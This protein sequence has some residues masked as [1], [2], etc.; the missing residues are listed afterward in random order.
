MVVVR[1]GFFFFLP[2]SGRAV[3]ICRAHP[4]R[5][6][7]GPKEMCVL[8]LFGA[9]NCVCVCVSREQTVCGCSL[10]TGH[11]SSMKGLRHMVIQIQFRYSQLPR[12]LHREQ[13]DR[14]GEQPARR[15][16]W[17]STEKNTHA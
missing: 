11:Y 2:A 17:E 13:P 5:R 1:A 8:G 6:R 4:V 14:P 15:K 16:G 7:E 10:P 3:N 9:T 12:L